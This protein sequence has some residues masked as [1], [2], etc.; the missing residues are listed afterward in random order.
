[1]QYYSAHMELIFGMEIR[2]IDWSADLLH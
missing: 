1:M 2:F